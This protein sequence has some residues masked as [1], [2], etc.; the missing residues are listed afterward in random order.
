MGLP[1]VQRSFF[2]TSQCNHNKVETVLCSVRVHAIALPQ[3]RAMKDSRKVSKIW[4]DGDLNSL[5]ANHQQT[6]FE[7]IARCCCVTMF[8]CSCVYAHMPLRAYVYCLSICFHISI[9]L[10]SYFP[11]FHIVREHE[12]YGWEGSART[13]QG[14]I[15]PGTFASYP[16]G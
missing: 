11:I 1:E 7:N 2:K 8:V 12:G 15:W 4:Y 10:A 6:N 16:R 9:L 3:T 5:R 13:I 14:P